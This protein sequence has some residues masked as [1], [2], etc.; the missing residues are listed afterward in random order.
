MK[1]DI[2]TL[3]NAIVNFRDARNWR[4]Y[5]N[6][7]DLAICL[8]VEAAELLE[9]FLWKTPEEAKIDSIKEELADVI[10]SAFLLAHECNLNIPEI[11]MDKLK[12]NELKYP[13]DL[14]FGKKEKYTEL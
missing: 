10:Y 7:K 1:T 5:H 2:E 9:I 6:P 14:S 11:V 13:V 12:K 3:T 8:N 4:Q